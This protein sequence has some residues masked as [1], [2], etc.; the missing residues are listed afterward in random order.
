MFI[1]NYM[2]PELPFHLLPEVVD[3]VL[4]TG[5]GLSHTV[6][7]MRDTETVLQ[8]LC[9]TEGLTF[10]GHAAGMILDYF[11]THPD[12]ADLENLTPA[13]APPM[14][15]RN[16]GARRFAP[17]ST[18]RRINVVL[19]HVALDWIAAACTHPATTHKL[20]RHCA[21]ILHRNATTGAA[22]VRAARRIGGL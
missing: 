21:L 10:W 7:V 9:A 4:Y 17:L 11:A 8:D 1:S 18:S 19:S 2:T 15:L 20:A 3:P 14:L 5:P 16:G 12:H 22:L 13:E 6:R